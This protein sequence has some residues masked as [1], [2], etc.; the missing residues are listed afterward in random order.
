MAGLKSVSEISEQFG[1]S[2]VSVRNWIL[3]GLPHKF[4][5]PIGR[6]R[7]IMIDPEDVIRY[8][9]AKEIPPSNRK[10]V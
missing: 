1:V 2:G 10:G 3:D 8:H 7:R 5:K 9:K 6:R 4:E